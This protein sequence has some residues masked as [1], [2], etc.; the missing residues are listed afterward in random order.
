[1]RRA[2][3]V[4]GPLSVCRRAPAFVILTI[5]AL[6]SDDPMTDFLCGR[7]ACLVL[8][9]CAAT[10]D[11]AAPP[12][13]R[14]EIPPETAAAAKRRHERVAE[15]RKG[16]GVICHRGSSELAHENT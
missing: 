10:A 8:L 5:P 2:A 4:N 1:M 16:T 9:A 6:R 12:A 15:R 13:V 11:A 7:T 3:K 14:P